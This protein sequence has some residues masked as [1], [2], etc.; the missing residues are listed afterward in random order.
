MLTDSRTISAVLTATQIVSFCAVLRGHPGPL[1]QEEAYGR[2]QR[3]SG[4]EDGARPPLLRA[5]QALVGGRLASRRADQAPRGKHH[6]APPFAG[7]IWDV[8]LSPC[9]AEQ[10]TWR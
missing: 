6:S 8:S 5:R 4:R 7:G 1:R 2:A 9:R 10:P 3:P